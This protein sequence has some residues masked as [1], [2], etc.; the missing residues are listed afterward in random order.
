MAPRKL[1]LRVA[2]DF[3]RSSAQT[4]VFH[5]A[6]VAEWQATKE[7]RFEGPRLAVGFVLHSYVMTGNRAVIRTWR[8][9]VRY[10]QNARVISPAIDPWCYGARIEEVD[11]PTKAFIEVQIAEDV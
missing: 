1:A 6:L 4:A 7:R 11:D 8:R 2:L 9:L 5:E 10:L 3:P